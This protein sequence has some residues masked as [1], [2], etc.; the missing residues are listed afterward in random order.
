MYM[1]SVNGSG[2]RLQFISLS[3]VQKYFEPKFR[4]KYDNNK[5][6][7]VNPNDSGYYNLK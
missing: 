6:Q 1:A 7:G 2:A 5:I 3:A 4:D